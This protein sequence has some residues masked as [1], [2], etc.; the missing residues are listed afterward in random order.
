MIHVLKLKWTI[1]RGRDTYGYTLAS[2]KDTKT[3]KFY[4]TCGGGYDMRGTVLG[5]WLNDVFKEELKTIAP[6]AMARFSKKT[7]LVHAE[8]PQNG[9][10]DRDM[11]FYGTYAYY[12]DLGNLEK[13]VID[14]S[15]GESEVLA[16]AKEIGLDV[17]QRRDLGMYF[18]EKQTTN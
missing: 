5:E 8:R 4:R 10:Y 9:Y 13:V 17:E 7:G 12:D 14:G 15:C 1:S 3:G 18:I 6:K 16:L 2:L 11:V